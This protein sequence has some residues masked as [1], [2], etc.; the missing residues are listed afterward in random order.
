MKKIFTLL[1]ILSIIQYTNA[2]K[3]SESAMLHMSD[4]DPGNYLL[5]KSKNLKTA[6]YV[7]ASIAAVANYT[8]PYREQI[9]TS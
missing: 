5:Q 3:I 2:Q 8:R 9:T 1:A 7:F 4:Q 6:G